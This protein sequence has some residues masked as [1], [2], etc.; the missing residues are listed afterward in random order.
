[1]TLSCV[2]CTRGGIDAWRHGSDRTTLVVQ[3][4][5]APAV[6]HLLQ[7]L[8]DSV[9]ELKISKVQLDG[10]LCQQLQSVAV[11]SMRAA[12]SMSASQ[13]DM[14]AMV[15]DVG[16]FLANAGVTARAPC[17]FLIYTSDDW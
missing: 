9:G 4:A 3:L 2:S 12:R 5:H 10:A 1:M 14:Q 6:A 15:A 8:L 13:R 17:L 16:S 7:R 11:E